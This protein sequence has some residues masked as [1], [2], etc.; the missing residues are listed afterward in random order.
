MSNII[1]IIEADL[2]AAEDWLAKE[3]EVIAEGLWSV[4]KVAFQ[5]LTSKQ[6]GVILD[7]LAKL[8]VDVVAKKS[9]EE[10][11]TDLLNL[12]TVEELAILEEVSSEMIQGLINFARAYK[13]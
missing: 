7:L 11:E 12:A 3:V 8:E 2:Q 10:I 1:T 6:V 5:A 13:A 9:V 4:L